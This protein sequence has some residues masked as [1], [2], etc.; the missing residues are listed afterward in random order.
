MEVL[1]MSFYCLLDSIQQDLVALHTCDAGQ[2]SSVS[3]ICINNAF[4]IE[5]TS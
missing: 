4:S 3:H 1:M 5:D 2:L